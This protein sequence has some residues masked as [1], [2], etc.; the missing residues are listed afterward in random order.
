MESKIG[1]LQDKLQSKTAQL[2]GF[3]SDLRRALDQASTLK[4]VH[5]EHNVIYYYTTMG[6]NVHAHVN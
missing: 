5:I 2:N 4:Q 3:H 6:Y 1:K